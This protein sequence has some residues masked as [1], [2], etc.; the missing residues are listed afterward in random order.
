MLRVGLVRRPGV[1]D[2]P[3]DD[4]SD[5]E[6]VEFD[7]RIDGFDLGFA[8]RTGPACGLTPHVEVAKPGPIELVVTEFVT[9]ECSATEWDYAVIVAR[10]GEIESEP[11]DVEFRTVSW[12]VD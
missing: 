1:V 3:S 9:D 5:I 4:L 11:V 8:R 12:P 6:Y 7:P 2:W 10:D